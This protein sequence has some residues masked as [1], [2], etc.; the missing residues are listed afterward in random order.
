MALSSQSPKEKDKIHGDGQIDSG[1]YQAREQR[2]SSREPQSI[3]E[4]YE[5]HNDNQPNPS[6][7][8]THQ[9]RISCR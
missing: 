7:R 9:S 2:L 1:A 3:G 8:A 4:E 5:Q 6:D